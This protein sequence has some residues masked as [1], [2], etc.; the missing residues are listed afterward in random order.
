MLGG[1]DASTTYLSV[2]S[3]SQATFFTCWMGNNDVLG[4]ATSGGHLELPGSQE[5]D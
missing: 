2:V 1:K 5:L 4:Y 3:E